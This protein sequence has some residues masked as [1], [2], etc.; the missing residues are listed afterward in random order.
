MARAPREGGG[1]E[2]ERVE[3]GERMKQ[4]ENRGEEER[5]REKTDLGLGAIERLPLWPEFT[6][7]TYYVVFVRCTK[8]PTICHPQSRC[9]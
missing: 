8:G 7:A 4:R 6:S 9:V 1:R 2:R 5:E 3:A